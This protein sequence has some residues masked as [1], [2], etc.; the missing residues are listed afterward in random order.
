MRR[1]LI[2]ML[3]F[4]MASVANA[5]IEIS[6]NGSTATDALTIGLSDTITV[7]IYNTDGADYGAF[8]G[9]YN[10]SEGL[11]ALSNAAL[12]PSAGDLS[13]FTGPTDMTGYGIDA[14]FYDVTLAQSQ[15]TSTIGSQFETDMHCLGEGAVVIQLLD[16]TSLAVLDTAT[17]TQI[18]EPATL[19]LLGLGGLLLRRRK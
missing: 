3:V 19:V 8:L 15:G 1:L 11:Y 5:A 12:T 7:D 9:F 2:L 14:D 18:P 16:N 6:L 17:I 13:T 10:R 4:G